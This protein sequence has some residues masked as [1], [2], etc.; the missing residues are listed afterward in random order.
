M[1]DVRCMMYAQ[2][3][4]QNYEYIEVSEEQNML[5]MSFYRSMACFYREWKM[6]SFYVFFLIERSFFFLFVE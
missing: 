2:N 3:I 6:C 1:W 5:L 4:A